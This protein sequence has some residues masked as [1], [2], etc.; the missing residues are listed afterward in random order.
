MSIADRTITRSSIV[1]RNSLYDFRTKGLPVEVNVDLS[2]Y[3]D[4]EGVV[5]YGVTA[6]RREI[7]TGQ[8]EELFDTYIENKSSAVDYWRCAVQRISDNTTD[9]Y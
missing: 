7:S 1:L 9:S 4:T 2:E 5:T 6:T 8:S 3:E